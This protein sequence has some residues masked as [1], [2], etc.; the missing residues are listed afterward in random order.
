MWTPSFRFE[1]ANHSF[2]RNVAISSLS[3]PFLLSIVQFFPHAKERFLCDSLYRVELPSIAGLG[4]QVLI[5]P[6][7]VNTT[8]KHLGF[9]HERIG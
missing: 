5:K 7:Q 8:M 9:I 4:V 2:Y 1:R 3:L 6:R